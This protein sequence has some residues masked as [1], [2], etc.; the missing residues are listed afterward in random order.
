MNT[1]KKAEKTVRNISKIEN[2]TLT[3]I[4]QRIGHNHAM[5]FGNHAAE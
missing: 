3:P 4:I 5:L 1:E 2:T